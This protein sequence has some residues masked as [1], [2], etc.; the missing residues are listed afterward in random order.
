MTQ[1]MTPESLDKLTYFLKGDKNAVELCLNL[2]FVGHLL[3]D[4]IDRDVE[5]TPEEIK[6]AF[7]ILMVDNVNN[8]FYQA[9]R[10]K[11]DPLMGSAI[12]L[13]F[14]STSLERGNADEKL[15]AFC[16]RNALLQVIHSCIL[17]IGGPQWLIDM[18]P[19][20]WRTFLLTN[21]KYSEFLQ[22]GEPCLM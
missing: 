2:M 6:Q 17:Y 1:P 15:T 11:L 18:G 20:F 9:F 22:E 7:R 12:M 8:P 5:R 16:I 14:D 21:Q 19:Q 3:D 13:W 4:L 10:D